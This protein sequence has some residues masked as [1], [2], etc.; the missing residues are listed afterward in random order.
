MVERIAIFI[1]T[2]VIKYTGEWLPLKA[3]HTR[4]AGARLALRTQSAWSEPE[5]QV[6]RQRDF[7][8]R[9]PAKCLHK[10]CSPWAALFSTNRGRHISFLRVLF[11]L[12]FFMVLPPVVFFRAALDVA[13]WC[14]N[15]DPGYRETCP[16]AGKRASLVRC[17]KRER[18]VLISILIPEVY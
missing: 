12:H 17:T 10:H 5:E 4:G 1:C 6:V 2:A 15:R 8:C 14:L 18:G 11:Y 16:L 13:F 7:T 3:N 9:Q